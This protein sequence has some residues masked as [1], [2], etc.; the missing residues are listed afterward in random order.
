M[1][2]LVLGARL[3]AA[4]TRYDITSEGLSVKYCRENNT[5]TNE[6]R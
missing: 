6:K 4:S 3:A 1:E 5:E 2:E